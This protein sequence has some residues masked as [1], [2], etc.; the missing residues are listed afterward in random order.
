[1]K[2]PKCGSNE[3]LKRHKGNCAKCVTEILMKLIKEAWTP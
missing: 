1:M 2:C 3:G